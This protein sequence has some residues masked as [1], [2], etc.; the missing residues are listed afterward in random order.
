[1][2]AVWHNS[3]RRRGTTH[4]PSHIRG[5][6]PPRVLHFSA[7]HLYLLV[8]IY[9]YI[10]TWRS[11]MMYRSLST[12]WMF[13]WDLLPTNCRS[14]YCI[15]IE[16]AEKQSRFVSITHVRSTHSLLHLWSKQ[17]NIPSSL[18][19]C[20]RPESWPEWL[21]LEGCSRYFL[22]RVTYSYKLFASQINFLLTFC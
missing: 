8:G 5:S 17:R 13:L 11:S 22:R 15:P 2:P 10:D 18:H 3:T 19:L 20:V 12:W 4:S 7:F 21:H 6:K 1:M 16:N 9:I 14:K